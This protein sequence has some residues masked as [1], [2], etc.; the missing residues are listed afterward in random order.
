[1]EGFHITS[2]WAKL[3]GREFA[4]FCEQNWGYGGKNVF[5][6]E[7]SKMFPDMDGP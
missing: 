1:M 5:T 3:Q 6:Y 2:W 7:K 4:F